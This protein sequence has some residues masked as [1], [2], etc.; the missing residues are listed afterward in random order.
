MQCSLPVLFPADFVLKL[1]NK[2]KQDKHFTGHTELFERVTLVWRCDRGL[3]KYFTI[4]FAKVHI[5]TGAISVTILQ[6]TE[7]RFFK[8]LK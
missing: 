1:C 7:K 5:Y 4:N 3:Q 8:Y 2:L 6:D